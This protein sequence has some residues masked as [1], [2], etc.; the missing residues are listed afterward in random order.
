MSA[1]ESVWGVWG[2]FGVHS[3]NPTQREALCGGPSGFVCGVCGVI[4]RAQA[5]ACVSFGGLGCGG[6]FH[7]ARAEKPNKPHTPHTVVS[8]PLF[9]KAFL[10][11][12][13]VWGMAFFVWGL[14]FDEEAGR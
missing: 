5:C 14:V 8:C 11:V 6:N 10:C 12:G 9:L 7:Y 3:G 13:F 1:P 4:A 2:L